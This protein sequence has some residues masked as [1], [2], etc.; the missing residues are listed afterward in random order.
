[1]L[2][3][4]DR[5]IREL[6]QIY[7]EEAWPSCRTVTACNGYEAL[8]D[9]QHQS[10]DLAVVDYR[11]PGMNGLELARIARQIAPT[12][13]LVLI[14]GSR[15][16]TIS[17]ATNQSPFDDYLDKPFTFD[18]FVARIAQLEPQPEPAS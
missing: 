16:Q 18:E 3:D 15:P 7:F 11:M 12:I 10:F 5:A 2:V 4:D 6:L 8:A 14:S 17:R 13:K 9:I 1:M